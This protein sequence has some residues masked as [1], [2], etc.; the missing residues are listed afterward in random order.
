MTFPSKES[1]PCAIF[2]L[3]VKML[4]QAQFPSKLSITSQFLDI[5][6]I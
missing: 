4:N 3:T 5:T 6:L 1:I 2:C